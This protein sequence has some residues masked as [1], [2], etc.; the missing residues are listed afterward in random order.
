MRFNQQRSILVLAIILSTAPCHITYYVNNTN[1][2]LPI[3]TINVP[4][5]KGYI[6]LT[7]KNL[8]ID[9]PEGFYMMLELEVEKVQYSNKGFE[10]MDVNF[11]RIE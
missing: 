1:Q 7:T 9:C 5:K 8:M 2:I 10:E 4:T 6:K 11:V 3:A